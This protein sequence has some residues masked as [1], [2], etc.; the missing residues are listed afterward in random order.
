MH[1]TRMLE[2]WLKRNCSFMHKVR[3]EALVKVVDGLLMSGK[4]T[5]AELGRGIRNDVMEKHNIKCADRLV[6]NRHL[7]QERMS[8]YQALAHWLLG[9]VERPWII[10]DWS[11]VEVGNGYVMLK[12]GVVVGGRAISVY[13]E[14][15]P[16]KHYCK[17]KVHR[18]FLE[19]LYQVVPQRCH[20]IIISDAGFRGPWF[21]A[22][23]SL[24][25]DWIGRVRKGVKFS[26]E[27]TNT[28]KDTGSLYRQ[29]TQRAKYLGRCWLSKSTPYRCA[30]HVYKSLRRGPGRPKK[31]YR[32]TPLNVRARKDAR[33]PWLL[34]TSLSPKYWSARRV[35]KAYEKRM[36]I[37]ETF[38][39][40][41]SHRWGYG[42]QYAR[43]GCAERL[44]NQ[45]LIT[46][47]AVLATWLVGMVAKTKGWARHFQANTVKDREVLSIF[48]LGRRVL[49]SSKSKFTLQKAD[50]WDAASRLPRIVKECAQLP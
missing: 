14:V 12:A 27:G 15:H 44:A 3:I 34:A 39:D 42:L 19:R 6:G 5:L 7:A 20:P 28:W 35:V 29:G 40:F 16:L 22:V 33:E 43:S 32:K 38:R 46:T 21:R 17:P 30:L 4:A 47:L 50:L 18:G 49:R 8:I 23:E 10:V 1:T 9:C 25:W 13:E 41:K 48:F 11:E 45:L 2:T 37:E 31:R 36:H 26:H 24:G